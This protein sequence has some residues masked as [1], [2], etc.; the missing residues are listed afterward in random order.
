MGDAGSR[1]LGLLIG[2]LVVATGNPLF[3]LLVGSVILLNGATGLVKVALMRFLGVAGPGGVRFP[4]HDHCRK[5]LRLVEQPGAGAL[6]AAAPGPLGPADHPGP[7]GAVR[8]GARA[9]AARTIGRNWAA[10]SEA[11]P[12]SAPPTSLRRQDL[13]GVAAVHR[14]AVED[15]RG[16]SPSPQRSTE[17][18]ADRAM[19]LLDLVQARRAPEP[20]AQTGS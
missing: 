19:H 14:A 17:R 7:E 18:R 10:V 8:C 20:I 11:P 12:T 13:G 9:Q 5:E 6:H 2:M 16:R 1:P 15:R 4:L 3:L